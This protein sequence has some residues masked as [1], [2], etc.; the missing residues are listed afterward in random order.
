MDLEQLRF[1]IGRY[2]KKDSYSDAEIAQ[3]ID[4]IASLPERLTSAVEAL[5]DEQLDTAYRPGGWTIRQVVHHIAD[6]HMNSIIRFKLSLSEETPTIKPYME[7]KWAEQTD[8]SMPIKPSMQIIDGVHARLAVLLRAMSKD[9]L[10]KTYLHPEYNQEFS[11]DQAIAQ[12]GWHSN[13]H[14]KHITNLT[15]TF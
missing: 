2:I 8:H 14:L 15:K 5:N 11:L 9:D 4:D 1:P 6:S 7:A 12:Y 13:H 10:K 3:H